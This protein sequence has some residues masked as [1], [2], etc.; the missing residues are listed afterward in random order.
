M[1][2]KYRQR[3]Y[4]DNS[5]RKDTPVK[6]KEKEKTKVD[7]GYGSRPSPRIETRFVDVIRCANCSAVVEATTISFT[8]QC[9]KCE[10]DL[11]SCK[12]CSYFDPGARFE[13]KK[14]IE[15]RVAKKAER[16]MCLLFASKV[17]VEKQQNNEA[18]RP[19]AAPKEQPVSSGRQAFENLFKK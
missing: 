2:R 15:L 11:H 19:A 14:P 9:K 13:C 8:E 3:G 6:E 5:E 4:Q 12:N 17:S 18:K 1:E 7:P 10:A 16:N